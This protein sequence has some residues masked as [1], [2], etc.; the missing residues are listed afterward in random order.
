MLGECFMKRQE[1]FE[2]T[3]LPLRISLVSLSNAELP[4]YLGSTLRGVLGR[5]LYET[6]REAYRFLYE[7]GKNCKGKQDIVK[8][9]MLIPPEVC[10]AKKIVEEGEELNFELLLL[11]NAAQY[12]LV[13]IKALQ[14]FEKLGLGVQRSPF[15]LLRV[16]NSREQRVLWQ[17]GTYYITGMNTVRLTC[18]NWTNVTGAV[19]KLCTPLRI[20]R[21]EQLLKHISFE[22]LIRNITSRIERL[23]ERYGGWVDLD[24]VTQIQLL[25]AKVEM[26]REE[27]WVEHLERYS[28]RLQ[29]K[30][31][32]SGLMGE[33]EYEGDLTPFVPWLSAAQIL[34]IG[35]NTTFGM[36]NI[37]VFFIEKMN[38]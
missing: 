24:E 14:K 12:V 16:I 38:R 34:H 26:T 21:G 28:N 32:F 8:P 17:R 2:I 22:T 11:G 7:N 18:Q 13:L 36:G 9:Y 15:R 6:D 27:L 4:A 35:R 31:D 19:V 25:S 30:M 29:E 1:L 37:Q 20:R 5:A 3:Y 23:T 10:G 33:I